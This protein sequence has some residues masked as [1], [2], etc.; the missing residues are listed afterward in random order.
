MP[1]RVDAPA[2]FQV[3]E[4]YTVDGVGTVVSGTTLCGSIGVG[5]TLLLG[6]DSLGRFVPVGIKGIHRRRMPTAR[7]YGGQACC[8]ALKKVKRNAVRKGM[9]LVHPDADPVAHWEFEGEVLVLHHPSTIT[10][11]YQAMV[12]VGSVRQAA[13]SSGSRARSTCAPA[14][15]RSAASASSGTPRCCRC[16]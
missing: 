9:V 11:K 2:Q 10:A 12:H 1:S 15:R 3:D 5:D 14:T 16:A 4:T 6:P 7:V 8:L 13:P